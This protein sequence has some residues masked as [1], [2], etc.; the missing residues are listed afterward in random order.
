MVLRSVSLP[1]P[2]LSLVF[3]TIQLD[4]SSA[5]QISGLRLP[6]SNKLFFALNKTGKP[7]LIRLL[8]Y[9]NNGFVLSLGSTRTLIGSVSGVLMLWTTSASIAG[10]TVMT[11]RI[12]ALSP[13]SM[14]LLK[15]VTL[16]GSGQ[17]QRKPLI[18]K[19]IEIDSACKKLLIS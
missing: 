14:M 15:S 10:G 3:S 17:L 13:V 1:S 12:V 18:V 9:S 7:R 2:S 8:V 5:I 6:V 16:A 4:L 11:R 19:T